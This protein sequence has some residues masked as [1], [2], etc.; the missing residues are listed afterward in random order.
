MAYAVV[1]GDGRTAIDRYQPVQPQ[2]A[3]R[4]KSVGD[5]S[6]MMRGSVCRDDGLL[7][8]NGAYLF[9][10]R[11]SAVWRVISKYRLPQQ[12]SRTCQLRKPMLDNSGPIASPCDDAS[13]PSN[14]KAMVVAIAGT[15]QRKGQ[16]LG[17]AANSLPPRKGGGRRGSDAPADGCLVSWRPDVGFVKRCES[18]AGPGQT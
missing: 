17:G 3:S 12:A 6:G 7:L 9:S 18:P 8:T 10:W 15:R 5:V 16:R 11:I 1:D 13:E 14:E 4:Y 2:T